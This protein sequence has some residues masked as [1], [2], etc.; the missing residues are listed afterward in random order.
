[1]HIIYIGRIIIDKD[2]IK[3]VEEMIEQDS[4]SG[5]CSL[6]RIQTFWPWKMS[7]TTWNVCIYNNNNN[8]V[9]IMYVYIM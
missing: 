6:V 2:R 5:C 8:Y 4:K 9:H 3:E 1:M 7:N